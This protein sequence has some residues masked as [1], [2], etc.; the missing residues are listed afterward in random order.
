MRAYSPEG[1]P[2]RGELKG[3]I[4]DSDGWP[5][6][7]TQVTLSDATGKSLATFET[8]K[9]GKYAIAW[10]Q[11]CA[12]CTIAV[13]RTGFE[14]QRRNVDYNGVNSLWFGF[15]L[16]RSGSATKGG[17]TPSVPNP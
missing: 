11:P 7:R 6:P 13:E 2:V 15:A 9:D 12:K 4:T 3:V 10:E 1:L 5:V 16:R 8:K 14:S 17:G